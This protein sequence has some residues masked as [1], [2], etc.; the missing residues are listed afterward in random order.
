MANAPFFEGYLVA[1]EVMAED[2]RNVEPVFAQTKPPLAHDGLSAERLARCSLARC[3]QLVKQAGMGKSMAGQRAVVHNTEMP[4]AF[5]CRHSPLTIAA[6]VE[7]ARHCTAPLSLLWA[8]T[9]AHT[10]L[11]GK[12]TH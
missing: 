12:R 10:S 4:P 11:F 7:R 1:R 2:K 6:G 8:H 9:H 3:R 5:H